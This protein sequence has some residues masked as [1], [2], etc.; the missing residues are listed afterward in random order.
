MAVDVAKLNEL[1]ALFAPHATLYCVGGYVRDG[2]LGCE[3]SDVDICSKLR[4]D[5]VKTLL[6]GTGFFVSDK[7]LRMGTV[8]ISSD[9]FVAEYTTFRTDSYERA[10]G[11][12]S[13]TE[14]CFTDDIAL[15]AR[16]RDFK[17][18]AVYKDILSGEIVDPTGGVHDIGNMVLSTADS[19][20]CVFEADGLRILRLVR[21]ASELGFDIE[22]ET[23]RVA[24]QNAWRVK[25]IAVERIRDELCKIFVSDTAHKSLGLKRA[26]LRGLNLLDELGLLDLLLPELAALK[27]VPQKKKYHLYD[28][29]GH[30]VKAFELSPPNLRWIALLHDL[31][32]PA[33]LANNGGENMHGH[34]EISAE[35]ASG[36]LNRLKFSNADKA[37]IVAA[38]RWHMTDLRGDMSK[39]KLR[40]FAVRHSDIMD[41]LSA[42]R[43][44][45]C[46]ASNGNPPEHNTLR[47]VWD[48]V[49]S[50]GTPLHIKQLKVDGNDLI[51]MG[52][53]REEIGR[54][55]EEL[56]DETVLNPS[57]ND[58]DKAIS[59]L[60]KRLAKK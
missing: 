29:Y 42:F 2:L 10:S 11:A 1:A 20:E 43:E 48:E 41:D 28:V 49:R 8:H 47:E 12:H 19:P 39:S 5:E 58:R 22:S 13:P 16:R 27:G 50:D 23:L 40:R 15:D 7:N 52:A 30:T 60:K 54:L 53:E 4:V 33:A 24:K 14:V 32:K 56:F 55:L 59:Y 21:F 38:V 57:M 35:L 18:N 25:D 26:H 3:S 6:A 51:A 45:D 37:H 34:D 31:G 46:L 36:I 17:C 9:G 44:I